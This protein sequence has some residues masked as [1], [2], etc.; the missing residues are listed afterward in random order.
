LALF[1]PKYNAVFIHIFKTA[2]T[3]VRL[4]LQIQDKSFEEIGRGHADYKELSNLLDLNDKKVFSVVRNPYE[5]IFSLYQ[6]A[7]FHQSHPFHPYCI[8]N[9]FDSFVLWYI[10]NMSTLS[11]QVNGKLQTQTEYLS[12]DTAIKVKYIFK[13]E[14]LQEEINNSKIF[15]NKIVLGKHNLTPYKTISFSKLVTEAINERF[16]QDFIN[17]KYLMQ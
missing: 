8:Y 14:N 4:A 12:D 15:S 9:N 7:A 6:Y 2:G 16:K 17:F 1:L 3:S 11:E 13:M 5:W 10:K